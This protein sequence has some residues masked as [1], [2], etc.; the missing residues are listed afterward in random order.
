MHLRRYVLALLVVLCSQS[1]LGAQDTDAD[2]QFY[3]D[4]AGSAV[5]P[6]DPAGPSGPGDEGITFDGGRPGGG[7]MSRTRRGCGRRQRRHPTV[8]Y[9]HPPEAH[10][11]TPG[12]SGNPRGRPK[13]ATARTPREAET[14][15]R[16]L[17]E[18]QQRCTQV[19]RGLR[20]GPGARHAER[21]K[22]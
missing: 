14:L 2:G 22:R 1:P 11:F 16:V 20:N 3:L 15:S 18:D 9:G 6:Y 7:A 13:G 21:S 17:R 5:F 4:L 8:G 12:Q 10:R 19:V